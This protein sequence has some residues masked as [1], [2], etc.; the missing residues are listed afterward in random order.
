LEE[1]FL[2]SLVDCIGEENLK[3]K[4]KEAIGTGSTGRA[5]AIYNY[6]IRGKKLP[7]GREYEPSTETDTKDYTFKFRKQIS[8]GPGEIF[9][10]DHEEQIPLNERG[11]LLTFKIEDIEF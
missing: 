11:H 2:R 10:I 4:V 7:Q 6:I 1:K 5:Q 9:K 3:R 8:L